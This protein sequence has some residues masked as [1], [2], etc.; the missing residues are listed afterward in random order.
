MDLLEHES[1]AD[2]FFS[3]FLRSQTAG[4]VVLLLVSAFAFFLANSSWAELYEHICGT[5][6]SIHAGQW[7]I[8]LDLAHWV[9]EALM[10]LFFFVVGLEIKREILVGELSQPRKASLAVFAALGGMIAPALIYTLFNLISPATRGG[11]GVPMATD[12][13][14][15]I[16]A[17]SLL[18][19]RVPISLKIFLTGLAIVD[20]LGAILVIAFFYADAF[21]LQ[22]LLTAMLF[23][24]AS[25]IYGRSGGSKGIVYALLCIGC[26]YFIL[27]SGI[28]STISGVLM[29]LTIPIR[30]KYSLSEVNAELKE[31][32]GEGTFELK[33]KHLE[34][35]ET[36]IRKSE[37]PLHRFEHRLH[38][39]VAWVVMPVFAFFNAGIHMPTHFTWALLFQPHVLGIFFGLLVGKPLG[40]LFACRFAVTRGWAQLPRGVSWRA[41][42]GVSQLAG[43]GFTMSLFISVLAFPEG[44]ATLEESKL[45]VLLASMTAMAIGLP[46]TWHGLKTPPSSPN[47]PS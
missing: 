36:I 37:S 10:V 47:P 26:W 16:G 22:A 42:I 44:S 38:P 28:H 41:M 39:W 32:F 45:G 35:L 25:W 29:A 27:E 1:P 7:Q 6:F 13:A 24:A 34:A 23:V 30:Q 43:L 40:V 15:A 4:G 31:S 33:E 14:F 19:K 11:W 8:D 9:N 5:H 3:A 17:L 20:D 18:G 21:S 2:G 12:I 46:L